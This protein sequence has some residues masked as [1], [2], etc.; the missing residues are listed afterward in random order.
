M[1]CEKLTQA[2]LLSLGGVVL[3]SRTYSKS[4]Y[5]QELTAISV[6]AVNYPPNSSLDGFASQWAAQTLNL[7]SQGSNVPTATYVNYAAGNEP[8]SQM[9]GANLQKLQAL[10]A[11]YDPSGKFNYYNPLSP[12]N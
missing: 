6:H 1:A 8:I 9:Y 12:K 4:T 11:L 7:F 3:S 2:H 10:K 5:E